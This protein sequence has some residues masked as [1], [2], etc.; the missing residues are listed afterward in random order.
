MNRS[1]RSA[2]KPTFLFLM[3]W[4]GASTSLSM[5]Q[6]STDQVWNQLYAQSTTA[7]NQGFKRLNYI[8]GYLGNGMEPTVNWP[9]DLVG[10]SSYLILGVCDNDC[11][12]FDLSLEDGDRGVL[13]SDVL[14]DD[15]PIVRFAPSKSGTYW[16]HP[17][18]VAC[19]V[20]PCGYGIVVFVK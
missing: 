8:I 9:V 20:E 6:T 18:M 10:G 19:S 4:L 16:I 1:P 5:A 17:T 2:W 12:D 15:L 3:V 7:Q 13:A 14:N 11:S